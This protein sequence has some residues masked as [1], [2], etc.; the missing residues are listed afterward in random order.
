[1]GYITELLK[2]KGKKYYWVDWAFDIML[3][4]IFIYLSLQV[5]D[6]TLKC[7]CPLPPINTSFNLTNFSFNL[8]GG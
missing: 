5:R 2:K 1:M 8:T 4:L 6:Y 7:S 3:A